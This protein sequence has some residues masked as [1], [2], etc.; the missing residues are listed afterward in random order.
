M[1]TLNIMAILLLL[2]GTCEAQ[3]KHA[4]TDTVKISGNCGMCKN[5]IEKAGNVKRVSAV[6]WNKETKLATVTYDADKTNKKEILK[7]IALVGYDNEAFRAPDKAYNALNGCC[8][9][10]RTKARNK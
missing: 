7:R 10:Q 1:K 9:Y 4:K 2:I 6:S 3:I 5:T 8:Q